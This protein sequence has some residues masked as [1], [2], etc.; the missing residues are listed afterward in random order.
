MGEA[1]RSRRIRA[2]RK[3]PWASLNRTT[4]TFHAAIR[5]GGTMKSRVGLSWGLLSSGG[6]MKARQL[7][8]LVLG[9]GMVGVTMGCADA[10]PTSDQNVLETPTVVDFNLRAG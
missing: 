9:L 7:G 5:S 4:E 2:E 6:D 10:K 8:G 1:S 3:A